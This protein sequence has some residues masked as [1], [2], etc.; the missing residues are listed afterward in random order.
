MGFKS[1]FSFV[2]V[3]ALV[4]GVF[5]ITAFAAKAPNPRES[6]QKA[7]GRVGAPTVN[8]ARRVSGNVR[9]GITAPG[10]VSTRVSR[11]G[12]IPS[13]TNTRNGAMTRVFSRSATTVS[14]AANPVK[15]VARSGKKTVAGGTG[16]ARSALSRATAIFNDVSKI[17]SGYAACRESYA[18][19]MDQMCA[20][21]NDTYRR[22]FC[23]ERFVKF[24][25]TEQ[26]LDQA[27]VMLRQFEDNNLNAVDKTA[28]EVS[29]MYSATVGEQAIKNDTSAAAQ[30]LNSIGDLLS[31]K[32]PAN[33][34]TLNDLGGID[35][36][37]DLGDIWGNNASSSI[38]GSN[39]KDLSELEGAALF[40]SAQQQCVRLT[41][42][43]CENDAV[44]NMAKSSYNILISQDCNLYE[45]TLNKKRENV[46]DAVR[47]A[48]KILRDARLEEYRSHNSA[49]VNECIDRVRTAML[50]DTACGADY[51]RCLDPTG[52]Y[53]SATT[54]EPIYSQRFLKLGDLTNLSGD[55]RGDIL[56][57]NQTYNT[58]L[59][60]YRQRAASALDTCRDNADY[61]WTEF[62]RAAIIEIAQAQVALVEEVKANCVSTI[63]ECYDSQTGQL[64]SF[65][66]TE[67]KAAGA[68]G[69]Y[70]AAGMCNDRVN[71]CAALYGDGK[72]NFDS[73]G[74]LSNKD[75]ND[76]SCGLK[77]LLSFVSAVDSV[78]VAELCETALNNYLKE[79]CTPSSGDEGYPWNCR[80]WSRKDIEDKLKTHADNNCKDPSGDF[81]AD[82]IKTKIDDVLNSVVEEISYALSEKCTD[83]NGYWYDGNYNVDNNNVCKSGSS[84]SGDSSSNIGVILPGFYSNVFGRGSNDE[85]SRHW[86]VCVENTVRTQCLAFNTDTKTVA[87]YNA[88]RDDCEFTEDWY[89]ERCE[90]I[91]GYYE[92]GTCYKPLESQ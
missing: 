64:N 66:T 59:D 57:Q 43:Q 23:S 14:R 50:Q 20:A 39:E 25:D 17:G 60:G 52:A 5:A 46:E 28:A 86:G 88:G 70:A 15:S 7:V 11:A 87:T 53:V 22:C 19:C 79:I 16:Y 38:F 33:S 67:S 77:A 90:L 48:E 32:I 69:R 51:K 36:S 85:D 44:F 63:A 3:V 34:K 30:V 29:A 74:R 8:T 49:D 37:S 4:C 81:A 92:G 13:S 80:T 35:F 41:Q 61:V 9:S 82:Q 91:G 89:N 1:R 56:N 2:S 71:M 73:K 72:C 12:R 6:N 18:T 21:A 83:I 55:M 58:Y 75:V 76:T 65:D 78:K 10:V 54:G 26:A 40:S 27:M 31:G 47:Q 68:I 62:K 45:K 42:S 84:C 24:R